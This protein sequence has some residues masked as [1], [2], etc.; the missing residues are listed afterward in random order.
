MRRLVTCSNRSTWPRRVAS[1]TEDRLEIDD[2]RI[3]SAAATERCIEGGAC[4]K[5]PT[6]TTPSKS[7]CI[8]VIPEGACAILKLNEACYYKKNGDIHPK[9]YLAD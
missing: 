5:L 4:D 8:N 2:V 3:N 1:Q 6:V 9:A 7:T